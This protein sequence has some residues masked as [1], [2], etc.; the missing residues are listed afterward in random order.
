MIHQASFF[1]SRTFSFHTC[2]D[3]L[4]RDEPTAEQSPLTSV[5]VPQITSGFKPDLY[6]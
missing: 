5:A 1:S 3:Y 6:P 2:A 4:Y